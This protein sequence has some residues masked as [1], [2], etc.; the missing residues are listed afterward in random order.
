VSHGVSERFYNQSDIRK[1]LTVGAEGLIETVE[2]VHLSK[3]CKSFQHVSSF[4]SL[5]EPVNE[6]LECVHIDIEGLR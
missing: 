5:Y 4:G 2:V 3:S 1:R 6:L